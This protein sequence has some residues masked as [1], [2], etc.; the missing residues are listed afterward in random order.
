LIFEIRESITN[1]LKF[2]N[3]NENNN[4]VTR[5]IPEATHASIIEML[6]NLET[7]LA[8]FTVGLT[9]AER[10]S[11]PKINVDN[12]MFIQ[13]CINEMKVPTSQNFVPVFLKPTDVEV[14]LAVFDQC[15]A[16][17]ARLASLAGR[18]DSTRLLGGSEAFVSA[19]T[20]KKLADAA[21]SAG[22][23]GA[24]VTARKLRERF[25]GQSTGGNGV[26]P[27]EEPTEPTE[28]PE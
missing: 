12:R 4:R 26:D 24:N 10:K 15:E 21:E 6:T 19:L 9:P 23:P 18:V 5:T 20:F 8:P 25:K 3:M 28:N 7:L 13:D 22:V 2:K 16:L 1:I 14:D 27:T 17:A 11:L